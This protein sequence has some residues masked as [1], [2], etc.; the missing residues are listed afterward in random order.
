MTLV[1]AIQLIKMN[2]WIILE[3]LHQD[4]WVERCFFPAYCLRI[5]LTL[6]V[7]WLLAST[8]QATGKMVPPLVL[9]PLLPQQPQ[10][11]SQNPWGENISSRIICLHLIPILPGYC[12]K[13]HCLWWVK[14]KKKTSNKSSN[15]ARMNHCICL[16]RGERKLIIEKWIKNHTY[17]TQELGKEG[18]RVNENNTIITCPHRFQLF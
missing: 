17:I 7:P 13:C 11:P 9:P 5:E 6:L 16:N 14:I 8:L 15:S 12:D 2:N 3:T 18:L 1:K 10:H 4:G